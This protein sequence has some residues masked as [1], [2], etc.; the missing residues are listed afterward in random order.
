MM[1]T[2]MTKLLKKKKLN[3]F[4][5]QDTERADSITGALSA[6]IVNLFKV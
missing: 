2:M 6:I 5:L 1:I 3:K 4:F